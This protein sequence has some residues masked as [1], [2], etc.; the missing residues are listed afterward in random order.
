MRASS[1]FAVVCLGMLLALG[2]RSVVAQSSFV[3]YDVPE[4]VVGNQ[5]FGGALGH[6]FD[7]NLDVVITRLGVFDSESDC[8]ESAG[9]GPLIGYGL[10]TPIVWGW[11][12][13]TYVVAPDH[14]GSGMGTFL[15]RCLLEVIFRIRHRL[16]S[17]ILARNAHS[18]AAA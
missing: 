11:A 4:G 2:S 12:Q 7:V 3:A 5:E 15:L 10:I 8:K 17:T 6:D 1:A 13:T 9:A 16:V 14:R 18:V